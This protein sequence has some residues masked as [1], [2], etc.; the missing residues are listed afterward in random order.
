MAHV[1]VANRGH[2]PF[3]D[4]PVARAYG[5]IAWP[6]ALFTAAAMGVFALLAG[7]LS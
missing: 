5:W 7:I 4:E 6:L 2:V 1:T 3:L